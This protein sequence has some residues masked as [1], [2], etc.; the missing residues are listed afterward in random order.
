[1]VERRTAEH[2][3]VDARDYPFSRRELREHTGWSQTQLRVHLER[4][5]DMEYVLVC[6]TGRRG[7][8]YQYAL[9]WDGRGKDSARF[10]IG[11]LDAGEAATTT[12]DWRGPEAALAASEGEMAGSW[13]PQNGAKSAGWRSPPARETT[14]E[15]RPNRDPKAPPAKNAR[16]GDNGAARRS[17]DVAGAAAARS[18]R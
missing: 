2:G 3:V 1:M 6:R 9:V 8:S 15:A 16:P 18:G 5:V 17:V 7:Q 10:V 12:S 13:R 14:D 4:L 11:L